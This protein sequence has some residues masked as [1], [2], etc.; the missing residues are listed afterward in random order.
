MYYYQVSFL[1]W[2][3]IQNRLFSAIAIDPA[4][5]SDVPILPT[6][7]LSDSRGDDVDKNL[8]DIL[9]QR[10]HFVTTDD[11]STATMPPASNAKS[12]GGKRDYDYLFKLVLIGDSGVGKSCLLLRF[13]VSSIFCGTVPFAWPKIKKLREER[14]ENHVGGI[15]YKQVAVKETTR[16]ALKLSMLSGHMVRPVLCLG[17]EGPER[18]ACMWEERIDSCCA[19]FLRADVM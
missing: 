11:P 18:M 3:P 8:F 13:A 2:I 5:A 16:V 9:D 10:R 12:P 14:T 17:C 1:G 15:E 7:K 19:L 4:I 6:L